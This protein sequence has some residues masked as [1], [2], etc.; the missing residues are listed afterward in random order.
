MSFTNRN[1]FGPATDVSLS[2]DAPEGMTAEPA[3]PTTAASVAPGET[4]SA[5]FRV[6]L[7]S[8]AAGELVSRVPVG[9]SYRT[10][11][12]RGSASAAVRLMAGT[13]V[14]APYRTAS[15]NDAVFGQ[16]GTDSPSKA[17]APICGVAPMSSARSTGPPPSVPP[18]S[19]RSR[20]PRRTTL[21]AGPAPG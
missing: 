15:F 9:A 5:S 18:R 13:G 16:S 21:A 14:Q 10:G 19:P 8:A 4:F 12:S 7:T 2:V 1:G 3:G 17:G 20:S 11:G 6:T